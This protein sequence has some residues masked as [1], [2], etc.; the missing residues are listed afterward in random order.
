MEA[1]LTIDRQGT[2]TSAS[3]TQKQTG[4]EGDR[5]GGEIAGVSQVSYK[6]WHS[7]FPT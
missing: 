2:Q 3:Q 5:V 1:D 7:S 6:S 4:R